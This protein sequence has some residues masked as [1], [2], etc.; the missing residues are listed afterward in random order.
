MSGL[1][2]EIRGNTLVALPA[3]N[4]DKAERK[5][6]TLQNTVDSLEDR[7]R[8]VPE[9]FQPARPLRYGLVYQCQDSGL[10]NAFVLHWTDLPGH[11]E[12]DPIFGRRICVNANV[13]LIECESEL[14][15][16][17]DVHRILRD[18]PTAI[19]RVYILD[20]ATQ[21]FD[22]EDQVDAVLVLGEG[23]AMAEFVARAV[24]HT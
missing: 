24:D 2:L 14:A 3:V 9:W 12:L 8:K 7:Q 11:T 15:I 19:V 6:S 20:P 16:A 23:E 18:L 17:M 10:F 21:T 4:A 13:R 1:L 22:Y 5:L